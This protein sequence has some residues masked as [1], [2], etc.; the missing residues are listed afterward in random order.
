MHELATGRFIAN[1][2]N[3]S[4]MVVDVTDPNISVVNGFIPVGW[5]PTALAGMHPRIALRGWNVEESSLTVTPG[6]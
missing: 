5:Y 1:A 2:D 4:V 3:N 6:R